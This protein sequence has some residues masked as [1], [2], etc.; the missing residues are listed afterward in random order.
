[1]EHNHGFDAFEM[2]LTETSKGFLREIAKWAY[3]LSIIGFIMVGLFVIGALAFGSIFAAAG[4]MGGTMGALGAM[5][6]TFITLF[7]LLLA[8][9]YFFPVYYL[10]KFSSNA[11][12]AFRNNDTESL[13]R[14]FGYLKSHYKFLGILTIV[15]IALY[16]L[17]IMFSI[18]GAASSLV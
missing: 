17:V 6:G 12:T 13:T 10:Y 15:F 11:K 7:Y 5:G 9:V 3:F 18:L 2:Q 1:M 8:A 16:V 4:S 14:S